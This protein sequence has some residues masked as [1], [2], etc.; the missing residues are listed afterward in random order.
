MSDLYNIDSDERYY[1]DDDDNSLD[2]G[3]D[4]YEEIDDEEEE[5][6]KK[7]EKDSKSEEDD[8]E[9]RVHVSF[10]CEDCDYRWDDIIVGNRDKIEREEFDIVCPMCGSTAVTQ[11]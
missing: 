10:A 2:D 5:E 3:N 1:D 6:E 7:K 11:I 4:Y 9:T 8:D